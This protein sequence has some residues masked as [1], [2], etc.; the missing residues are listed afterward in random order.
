MRTR[1]G[2]PAAAHAHPAQYSHSMSTRGNLHPA[3]YCRPPSPHA[4]GYTRHCA[5]TA[6][7][8]QRCNRCRRTARRASMCGRAP[9]SLNTHYHSCICRHSWVSD[10]AGSEQ[11]DAGTAVGA[12]TTACPATAFG[13]S[14]ITYHIHNRRSPCDR[15]HRQQLQ[16]AKRMNK[17]LAR[18][19]DELVRINQQLFMLTMS[20]SHDRTRRLAYEH[21]ASSGTSGHASADAPTSHGSRDET[22]KVAGAEP[23][24]PAC[25]SAH[26]K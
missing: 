13:G 21:F 10:D 12:S 24:R 7:P 19:Y 14:S 17:Q 4:G 5:L 2:E 9:H 11:D 1:T 3:L 25:H 20:L 6:L 26:Q 8:D 16:E 22:R 15:A 18:N 23:A